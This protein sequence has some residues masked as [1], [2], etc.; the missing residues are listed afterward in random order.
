[1]KVQ[2]VVKTVVQIVVQTGV[3]TVDINRLDKESLYLY[4]EYKEKLEGKRFYEK[5]KIVGACQRR[6]EYINL[7]I[8][9]QQ[10]LLLLLS[11]I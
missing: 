11:R 1:M 3:E 4:E 10:D 2:T 6:Q 9:Q 8:E 7:S 5:I